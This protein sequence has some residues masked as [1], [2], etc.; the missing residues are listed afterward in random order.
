MSE[1]DTLLE[2]YRRRCADFSWEV[3]TRFNFGRDV[4]DQH[5]SDPK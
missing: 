5:G 2:A 3:P 1:L 4:V